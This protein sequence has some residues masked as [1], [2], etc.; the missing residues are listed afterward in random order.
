MI[1]GDHQ[2][3]VSRER[4]QHVASRSSNR[5]R[6]AGVPLDVVAVTVLRVEVHEVDEDEPVD[7]RRAPDL[8]TR[9]MPVRVA[10]RNGCERCRG[11][12]NRSCTLPIDTP[13][14]RR[15]Q[16]IEQRVA[17]AASARS[18]AGWPCA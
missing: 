5:S 3:V 15:R 8:Q 10:L 12:A 11:P 17:A 7:R 16:E 9:S 18:R 2:Q 13:G 14:C 1:G 6:F 4:R